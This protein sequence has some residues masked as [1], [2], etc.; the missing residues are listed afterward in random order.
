[1]REAIRIGEKQLKLTDAEGRDLM[2]I[3]IPMP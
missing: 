1:M 2:E 3:N